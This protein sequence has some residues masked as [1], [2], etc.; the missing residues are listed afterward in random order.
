MAVSPERRREMMAAIRD[1]AIKVIGQDLVKNDAEARLLT[2]VV[3]AYGDSPAG[4]IYASP[5]RARSTMRPPDVVLCHPQVGLLIIEA[6]G[7]PIDTVEGVDAGSIFVRRSGY[8]R[9]ENPVRQAEDQMFDIDNDISRLVR[10][11]WERPLTNCMVAFP[12]I[13]ESEWAARGYDKAHPSSQLL[14]REQFEDLGR[15]RKRVDRLVN[16]TLNASRKE[17]PLNLE[18][19][20]LIARVFGNSDVINETRPPRVHV[21]RESLGGYIDEWT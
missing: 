21:E 4:F 13:S 2:T 8:I 1:A 6:K 14:F 18:Q 16:E 20:K 11:R 7:L 9:A 5:S 17:T 3:R 12:L 19:V 15:L 10:N